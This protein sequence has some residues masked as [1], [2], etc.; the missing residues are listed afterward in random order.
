MRI[1]THPFGYFR[2]DYE[3][4]ASNE[5]DI[6]DERNGRFCIAPDYPQGT[7]AIALLLLLNIGMLAFMWRTDHHRQAREALIWSS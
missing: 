5:P 6:L 7:Y 2:E 3:F 4:I 1:N